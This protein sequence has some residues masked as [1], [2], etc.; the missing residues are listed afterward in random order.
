VT[1]GLIWDMDGVLIDSGEAHYVAWKTLFDELGMPL[2]A[3]QVS[4]T[5]GMSNMPILR[6]W[7]GADTP[8]QTL[9]DVANRKEAHFRSLVGEHVRVLPGVLHWLARARERGYR[10][11]VASSAPMANIVAI[12]E[13]LGIGDAFDVLISGA[14]LPASKPDPAIFVQ[15]ARGLG[16]EPSQCVVLE[17]STVGIE[18]AV[19]AGM[20]CVAVTNTRPAREL[21]A[22]SLIV[23]S[24]ADLPDDVFE[25]LTRRTRE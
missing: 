4:R 1:I 2:T 6:M 10:Q 16:C 15:A 13:A 24:L 9:T 19:R 18:A 21:V 14:S 22:A 11:A 20:P 25:K 12:L 23:D 3:E 17:D 7:L 8:V 5:L